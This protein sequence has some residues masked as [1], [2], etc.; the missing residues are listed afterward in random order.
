MQYICLNEWLYPFDINVK[1]IDRLDKCQSSLK[2][3]VIIAEPMFS[4]VGRAEMPRRDLQGARVPPA[5]RALPKV[6]R[7]RSPVGE[8]GPDEVLRQL[9]LQNPLMMGP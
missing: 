2:S 3:K 9:E 4:H 8:V 5:R 1:N 7:L 6:Q